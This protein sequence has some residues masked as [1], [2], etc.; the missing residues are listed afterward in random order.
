[1]LA[2]RSC[3]LAASVALGLFSA[4]AGA[5]FYTGDT[6]YEVCTTGRDSPAYFEKTYECI[7][8]I[9]GAVDAFNRT[10][11]VNKLKSCIPAEVTINQLKAVTVDY[12]RDNPGERSGSASALVFAA[13]RKAWPC[14]KKKRR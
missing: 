6:L 3:H 7:G 2:R 4:A 1:M 8:Y 5:S 10:R 13:T 14:P 9:T 11:E 12:L